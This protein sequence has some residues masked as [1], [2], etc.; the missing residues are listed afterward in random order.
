MFL[1]QCNAVVEC[2]G[3]FSTCVRLKLKPMVTLTNS[4]VKWQEIGFNCVLIELRPAL[5]E[6]TAL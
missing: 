6:A 4:V 3:E 5:M 1:L 2:V